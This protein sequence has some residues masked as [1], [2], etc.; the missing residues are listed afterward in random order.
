[1]NSIVYLLYIKYK[2]KLMKK[3]LLLL[4]VVVLAAVYLFKRIF[5]KII[6]KYIKPQ[7]YPVE[8][9]P[10]NI[11]KLLEPIIYYKNLAGKNM[12]KL[13]TNNIGDK[14]NIPAIL[15]EITYDFIDDLHNASLVI[16]DIQDGSTLRRNNKTSHLKFGIPMSI[17]ASS[18]YIFKRIKDFKR[19]INDTV[20]FTELSNKHSFILSPEH[21]QMKINNTLGDTLVDLIY[22][23]N[24]GQQ[25]DVYWTYKKIIPTID[26]YNYMVKNKTG[27]LFSV[28]I[29]IFNVLSSNITEKQYNEYSEILG[30]VGLFYQ[31]RDDYINLCDKEYWKLKG[32]CEDFDE[33]KNSYIIIKYCNEVDKTERSKFLK[34]FY[35]PKLTKKDKITLLKMINKTTIFDDTYEYLQK[36]KVNAEKVGLP[37]EKLGFTPFNI[38]MAIEFS[39][40]KL[41][42]KVSILRISDKRS[43]CFAPELKTLD[44]KHK[45]K[46]S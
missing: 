33:K 18:L 31:I 7:A 13:L 9:H 25:M 11:D 41:F 36:L 42:Q 15:I 44:K 40:N 6:I 34:L 26:E 37:M 20:D 19:R 28:I 30:N 45:H 16:D 8:D 3:T 46:K 38:K 23:M 4:L 24:V 12:R 17:G 21:L 35:K 10:P 27:K 1:M 43:G 32:F 29:D 5:L 14:F 2:I 22:F 39:G